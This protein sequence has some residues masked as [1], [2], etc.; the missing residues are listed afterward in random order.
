MTAARREGTALAAGSALNG[1]LA[2]GVF[3]STTHGLGA[4][5]A[6]PV[7]VLW[8]LWALCGAALT[9]PVQHWITSLAG[10]G[11]QRV[12][13]P[14][15]GRVG[16]LTLAVVVLVGGATAVLREPL[17]GRDDLWFPG[18]SACVALG[19]V[20]IGLVRGLLAAEG[21]FSWL[22][23]SLSTENA[24]RFAATLLLLAAGSTDPVAYGVCLLTGY[25]VAAVAPGAWRGSWGGAEG[26]PDES[27]P[28]ELPT[29]GPL[30]FLGGAG[31]AQLLHQIVLTAGP[32]TAAAL[33]AA[34]AAV[35]GLF[36]ASALFR[37]PFLVTLG[38]APRVTRTASVLVATR[39]FDAMSRLVTRTVLVTVVTG[40]LAV[41]VAA[42]LG[43]PLLRLLFGQVA[44]SS[45]VATLIA[46][47][48]VLAVGNLVT[49]ILTLALQRPGVGAAGWLVGT[50]VAAA[51]LLWSSDG[52]LSPAPA[53]RVAAAFLAAEA[54]AFVVLVATTARVVRARRAESS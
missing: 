6:A 9:F 47:G 7:A 38:V 17:F 2:Y 11:A 29:T 53:D 54:T 43:P 12:G 45:P 8:S 37:A 44:V 31:L 36:A 40:V 52:Q 18:L 39:R 1:L 14:H 13:V 28:P 4:E 21:R 30:R 10:A 20:A 16:L 22:A 5:A 26:G 23:A 25:V 19:A 46:V 49:G 35:T 41:P 15:A 24:V 48:C 32:V 27:R 34:P 51:V 42:W 3:A 50:A 33:G